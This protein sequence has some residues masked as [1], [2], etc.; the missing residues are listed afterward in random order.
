[1]WLAVAIVCLR[2]S[3]QRDVYT[4]GKDRRNVRSEKGDDL[5]GGE[6]AGVVEAREDRVDR[7]EWLGHG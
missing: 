6:L 2:A 3:S 1:M 7:V 4:K 5:G